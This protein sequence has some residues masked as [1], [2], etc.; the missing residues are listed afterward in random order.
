VTDIGRL[1]TI[2]IL[3]ISPVY[4]KDVCSPPRLSSIQFHLKSHGIQPR[5]GSLRARNTSLST[6]MTQMRSRTRSLRVPSLFHVQMQKIFFARRL[7]HIQISPA[8]MRRGHIRLIG[9][10][11]CLIAAMQST[12]GHRA[13]CIRI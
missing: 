3:R 6:I 7:S 9:S 12:V 10:A 11:R 4:M 8:S 2:R 5:R 1:S 13:G